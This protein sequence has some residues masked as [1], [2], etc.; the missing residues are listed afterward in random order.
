M[1]TNL[2]KLKEMSVV[3][4]KGVL[5]NMVFRRASRTTIVFGS[6][7]SNQKQRQ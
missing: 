4:V 7:K 6:R 5:K 3:K 1:L 2:Q